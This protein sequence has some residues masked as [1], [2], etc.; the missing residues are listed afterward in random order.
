MGTPEAFG[1]P[2]KYVTQ[3]AKSDRGRAVKWESPLLE[4]V[5]PSVCLQPATRPSMPLASF[6]MRFF[7]FLWDWPSDSFRMCM[8]GGLA[9]SFSCFSSDL[10]EAK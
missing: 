2:F 4:Q 8:P 3:V 1:C 7:L 10:V 9:P 6:L 5:S